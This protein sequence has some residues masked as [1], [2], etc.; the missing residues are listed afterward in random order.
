MKELYYELMGWDKKTGVPLPETLKELGL[1]D[2][3]TNRE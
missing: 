2:V 1:N 3:V